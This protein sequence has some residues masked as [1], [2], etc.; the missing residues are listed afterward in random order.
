MIFLLQ[1]A[2]N[3]WG[4]AVKLYLYRLSLKVKEQT[5]AFERRDSEGKSFERRTWLD[6]IFSQQ[7]TFNHR[8]SEFYFV[9]ARQAETNLPDHLI[10]GWIA[11]DKSSVERTPPW[12]GLD[13][14]EHDSWQASLLIIDPTAH[15]DGQKLALE[16]RSDVGKTD[17]VISSLIISLNERGRSEPFSTSVFPI[18]HER[19]F[20]QFSE[21]NRGKIN[22]ITYDVAVPNM[23]D[24][25]DDHTNE[26]RNLRD[27]GNISR[28]KTTLESDG[29]INIEGTQ[30]DEIA[31]HVEKGGGT[32]SAKTS[33]GEKY[34][35]NDYA[36]SEEV[37]MNGAEPEGETFWHRI[38]DAADR[39]F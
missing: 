6:D 33:D 18:I 7:F 16:M 8:S 1:W 3:I 30:L 24:S 29:A 9:P 32:I 38:K 22:K 2:L 14:T 19:S 37:H 39:I 28:A 12:E 35:S 10:T 25:A 4:C 26:M 23:F 13:P 31:A 20:M 27:K 15:E 11:R 34:N 21:A 5:D 36:V 17:P